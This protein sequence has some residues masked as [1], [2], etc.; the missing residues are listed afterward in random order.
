MLRIAVV[1]TL[2]FL[3]AVVAKQP[4]YCSEPK[5][6][7]GLTCSQYLKS[8]VGSSCLEMFTKFGFIEKNNLHCQCACPEYYEPVG[9]DQKTCEAWQSNKKCPEAFSERTWD[10]HPNGD[11]SLKNCMSICSNIGEAACCYFSEKNKCW[12]HG[13]TESMKLRKNPKGSTATLCNLPCKKKFYVTLKSKSGKGWGAG[14]LTIRILISQKQLSFPVTMTSKD[15]YEKKVTV[16]AR[17]TS[18]CYSAELS[19]GRGGQDEMSFEIKDTSGKISVSHTGPGSYTFGSGNGCPGRNLKRMGRYALSQVSRLKLN[20]INGKKM[21]RNIM[22]RSEGLGIQVL[23]LEKMGSIFSQNQ[24]GYEK[25][26]KTN[27]NKK[28]EAK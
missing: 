18:F 17:E 21:I 8:G 5:D 3:P 28:K 22:R 24:T 2:C 12:S 4:L 7:H 11:G 19:K 20:E 14:D 25:K 1:V 15:S 9:E 27:T 10:Y 13:L 26:K 23:P 6:K 16:C